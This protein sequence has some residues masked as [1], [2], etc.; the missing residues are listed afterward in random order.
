MKWR[1]HEGWEEGGRK[2]TLVKQVFAES[3]TPPRYP[4]TP[5]ILGALINYRFLT[6]V[7][8]TGFSLQVF[9]LSQNSVIVQQSGIIHY[10]FHLINPVDAPLHHL[11]NI[12]PHG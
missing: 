7:M 1:K 5:A 3:S 8:I 9:N 11:A 12:F 6:K 2:L 10:Q 4:T